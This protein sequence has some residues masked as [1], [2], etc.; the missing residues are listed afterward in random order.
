MARR[1]IVAIEV[2]IGEFDLLIAAHTRVRRM[3]LGI[4][5]HEVRN[6][7]RAKLLSKVEALPAYSHSLGSGACSTKKPRS[8]A[9]K[10][11]AHAVNIVAFFLKKICR[12]T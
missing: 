6:Y 1:N 12:N 5:Q 3:A 10:L 4:A 9:A 11:E 8:I 2:E 7:K